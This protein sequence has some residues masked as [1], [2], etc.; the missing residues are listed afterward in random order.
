MRSFAQSL[1]DRCSVFPCFQG[2]TCQGDLGAKV[3]LVATGVGCHIP[4]LEMLELGADVLVVTLDR[5][6]Q[7]T[8]RIPLAEMGANVIAVEHGVA[9]MPGM[10]SMSHYLEQAFPG[11]SATFYCEEPYAETITGSTMP[12]PS[13]D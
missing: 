11:I 5:A 13:S 7:E 9:E 8:V 10:R 4:T 6:L 12:V 2:A 3:E 1:S